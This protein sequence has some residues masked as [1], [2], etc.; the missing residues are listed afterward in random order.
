MS[1]CSNHRSSTYA[2]DECNSGS[3]FSD[4]FNP[5]IPGVVASRVGAGKKVLTVDMSSYVNTT[6]LKDGLHPTDFGYNQ[7][8]IGWHNGI[9]QAISMGWITAPVAVNGISS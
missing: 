9:Q 7:M 8:A 3:V 1:R 4:V 6:V 5:D 2:N